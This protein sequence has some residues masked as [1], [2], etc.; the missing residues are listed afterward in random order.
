MICSNEYCGRTFEQHDRRQKYCSPA[1]LR[2][3]ASR[4]HW[5]RKHPD[6]RRMPRRDAPRRDRLAGP[7][8]WCWSTIRAVL[9]DGPATVAEL[10]LEVYGG[11]SDQ[12]RKAMQKMLMELSSTD[13]RGGPW[14]ERVRHGEYALPGTAPVASKQALLYALREHPR[15]KDDLARLL[16]MA[17]RTVLGWMQ[18]LRRDGHPIEKRHPPRWRHR[19][20]GRQRWYWIGKRASER[21]A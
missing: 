4:N 12:D 5:R 17:P 20:Q 10:A 15:T 14:L 16:G 8:C 2:K 11:T 6:A 7:K 19:E 1:C 21:A 9:E 18:E 3:V 13:Y